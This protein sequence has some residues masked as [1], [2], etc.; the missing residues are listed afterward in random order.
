MSRFPAPSVFSPV[1]LP[2]LENRPWALA[3]VLSLDFS[4]RNAAAIPAG[5]PSPRSL[6]SAGGFRG[7]R[8]AHGPFLAVGRP[9][10]RSSALLPFF[11]PFL[12]SDLLRSSLQEF[13]FK[14]RSPS[15]LWRLCLLC[16]TSLSERLS[17][18]VPAILA[19]L[20]VPFFALLLRFPRWKRRRFLVYADLGASALEFSL[21]SVNRAALSPFFRVSLR[22]SV[23]GV[24]VR[25]PFSSGIHRFCLFPRR[26]QRSFRDSLKNS[27]PWKFRRPDV[28][29]SRCPVFGSSL[30]LP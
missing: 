27:R 25:F 30:A 12:S 14:R 18:A 13:S 22:L 10:S 24:S 28:R 11:S 21:C 23:D 9:G 3:E 6:A 5:S 7:M 17:R 1:S 15:W 4:L 16:T 20:F 26:I 19:S 2:S 29:S 8:L